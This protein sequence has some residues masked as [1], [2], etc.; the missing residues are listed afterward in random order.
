M[1]KRAR[2]DI[3]PANAITVVE[4]VHRGGTITV[5]IHGQILELEVVEGETTNQ[6]AHRLADL[7]NAA[8]GKT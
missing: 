5:F 2:I 8:K 7:I 1:S 4:S 6:V 3:G